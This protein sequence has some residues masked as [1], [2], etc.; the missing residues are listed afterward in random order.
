MSDD[1]LDMLIQQFREHRLE[2]KEVS[3]KI[4]KRLCIM[5][6]RQN[7]TE[8]QLYLYKS[9]INILK[10]VGIAIVFLVTFKFGDILKLFGKG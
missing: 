6:D 4:E 5:E 3:A 8:T 10:S 9:L 2:T 1:K 7:K